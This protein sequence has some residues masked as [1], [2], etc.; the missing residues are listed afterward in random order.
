MTKVDARCLELQVMSHT[1]FAQVLSAVR[2]LTYDKIGIL[3]IS[4]GTSTSD[5]EL[6]HAFQVISEEA[7]R[8]IMSVN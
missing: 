2:V 4:I 5:K 3:R 1:T 8:Q 6:E 7:R